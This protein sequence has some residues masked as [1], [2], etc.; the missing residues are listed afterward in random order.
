MVVVD[1]DVVVLIAVEREREREREWVRERD[2]R[3]ERDR[4]V[5]IILLGCM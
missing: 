3:E 2:G 4:L 1:C 5:S